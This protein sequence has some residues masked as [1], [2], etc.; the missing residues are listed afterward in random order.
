MYLVRKRRTEK[1]EA[2][3]KGKKKMMIKMTTKKKKVEE[4]EEEKDKKKNEREYQLR[5]KKV[6]AEGKQVNKIKI[7]MYSTYDMNYKLSD[8]GTETN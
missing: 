6:K 2:K 7:M 5:A 4:E 1:G 8:N 3:E